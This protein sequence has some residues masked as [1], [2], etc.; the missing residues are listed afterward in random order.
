MLSFPVPFGKKVQMSGIQRCPRTL[1][2][3]SSD[4]TSGNVN[5]GK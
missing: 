2:F 3:S 5:P 4:I 1:G